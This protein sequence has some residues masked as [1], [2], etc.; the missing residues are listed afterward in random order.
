MGRHRFNLELTDEAKEQVDELQRRTGAPSMTE[1][2][3]RAL[4]LYDSYTQHRAD[5]WE[6]VLRNE[7]KGTERVIELP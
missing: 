6:V 4:R 1:V 7:K 5:G 2:I 3:R